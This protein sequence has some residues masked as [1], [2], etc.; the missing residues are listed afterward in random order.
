MTTLT[1]AVSVLVQPW[2]ARLGTGFTLRRSHGITGMV[3][4]GENTAPRQEKPG[5]CLASQGSPPHRNS[6]RLSPQ[7]IEL[8]APLA[9]RRAATQKCG[10]PRGFTCF[11]GKRRTASSRWLSSCRPPWRWSPLPT[12][13]SMMLRMLELWPSRMVLGSASTCRSA[14]GDGWPAVTERLRDRRR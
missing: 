12:L 2:L 5:W 8:R 4:P 13:L 1:G 11:P 14:S 10:V 7:F 3:F 6:R 9:P